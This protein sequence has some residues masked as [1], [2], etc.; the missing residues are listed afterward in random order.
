MS[1]L[2]DDTIRNRTSRLGSLK[3]FQDFTKGLTPLQIGRLRTPH[4]QPPTDKRADPRGSRTI[5]ALPDSR[6]S[7]EE[8]RQPSIEN[9]SAME[10]RPL[11]ES[12]TRLAKA[13]VAV[14]AVAHRTPEKIRNAGKV[15]QTSDLQNSDRRAETE[16][17][18]GSPKLVALVASE[19]RLIHSRTSVL[20]STG[21][22]AKY[23][24]ELALVTRLRESLIAFGRD[25][26]KYSKLVFRNSTAP[27]V[28]S[29]F[30]SIVAG[31][32]RQAI[33]LTM[34]TGKAI[35][36]SSSISPSGE[37]VRPR[38]VTLQ[39]AAAIARLALPLLAAPTL[40]AI[41]TTLRASGVPNRPSTV[42]NSA[43]TVVINSLPSSDIE[44]RV[45]EA[46]RQHRDAL[47]EQWHR[48]VRRRQRTE[49]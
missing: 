17:E 38:P 18:S 39:R 34:V 31:L 12:W 49:F 32:Q 9:S 36:S 40:A 43:P 28:V 8:K 46:L 37:D 2:N 4:L 44:R 15:D 14:N 42:I 5:D 47:Y 27:G 29:S 21:L 22:A 20:T 24:F 33:S 7:T 48:E 6:S 30:A 35:S 10:A 41:P 25:V 16:T 3:T 13:I 1:E 45:L 19:N 23:H 11:I 26:S